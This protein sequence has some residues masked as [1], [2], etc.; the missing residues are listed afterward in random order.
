MVCIEQ[1]KKKIF[2]KITTSVHGLHFYDSIL[3]IEKKN[4]KEPKSIMKGNVSVEHHFTD[5]GQ[6]KKNTTKIKSWL[7]LRQ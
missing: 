4:I 5:V 6:K 2:N 7:K 3:I 1:D